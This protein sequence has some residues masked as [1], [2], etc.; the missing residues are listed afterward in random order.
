MKGIKIR[1]E[2]RVQGVFFR[3]YTRDKAE[4]LRLAGWVRNL[5]DG[6]VEASVEGEATAVEKMLEWFWR[7]SPHAVVTNIL[8]HELDLSH[9]SAPF[10]IR[11]SASQPMALPIDNP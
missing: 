11:P 6:R 7:G 4:E 2:G 5:T 8:Q 9:E 1:V 3:A 10:T